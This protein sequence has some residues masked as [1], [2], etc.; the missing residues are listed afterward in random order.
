MDWFLGVGAAV[1]AFGLVIFSLHQ[2]GLPVPLIQI[3]PITNH[4]TTYAT[5]WEANIFGSFEMVVFSLALSQ[6]L[7]AFGSGRRADWRLWALVIALLSLLIS[8]TRAAW[9]GALLAVV[10]QVFRARHD[11]RLDARTLK[12]MAA[13]AAAIGLLFMIGAGSTLMSRALSV[14]ELNAGSFAFRLI[15]Y[16]H[17]IEGFV[18]SPLLGLGTNSF[19][20]R[21]IDLSQGP[22]ARDYLP[23]LFL[24]A[25][26]DTGILGFAVMI[27][28]FAALFRGLR[29]IR[30][31]AVTV[32][33]RCWAAGCTATL[34]AILVAY[35][36]T[37]AY[38]FGFS[39]VFFVLVVVL[40]EHG[41]AP[42][43]AVSE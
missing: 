9:L 34:A 14:G 1:G 25:L 16:Q 13:G 36:T 30:R 6:V 10:Y 3:D 28:F 2:I 20:Q 15:R 19:G 35:Q 32:E 5:M 22:D 17:A 43:E 11:L 4:A 38:W 7:A 33:G 18:S 40:A 37:S 42:G 41:V 24:Q 29:Q 8:F 31:R 39:W 26:Y 21:F 12:L 23:S 27:G